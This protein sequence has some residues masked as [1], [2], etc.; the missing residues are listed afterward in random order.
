MNKKLWYEA[1]SREDVPSFPCPHCQQTTLE[2]Q[3]D[4]LEVHE[5]TYS[6]KGHSDLDWEPDWSIKRF[7][8]LLKCTKSSCGEFVS[9]AGDIIVEPGYDNDGSWSYKEMLRP[10]NMFPAPHIIAL[11]EGI[12]GP[13]ETELML[14]FQLFWS[15]YGSCATKLRTSVER[16]MDHFKVVKIYVAKDP[17]KPTKAGKIRLYDLA[18]R[19]DK[20]IS[21]TGDVVHKDHLHAL[22][23]VGNVGT[24]KNE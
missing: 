23:M 21:T 16:L 18:V 22:R 11:P 15:D 1:F 19:I 6:V 5:P 14:A 10:R 4:T 9:I 12:P 8:V 7:I 17:K 20:F 2:L 13:V 3:K 24:H